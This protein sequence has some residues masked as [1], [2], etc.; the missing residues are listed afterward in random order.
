M[1][2]RASTNGLVTMNC[3]KYPCALVNWYSPVSDSPDENMGMW[4]IEHDILDN[5][6]LQMAVVHLDTILCLA[7]LL[8]I[9]RFIETSKHQWV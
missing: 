8:P 4:V 5:G 3:V 7:H 9:Y 6:K 1:T 2:D